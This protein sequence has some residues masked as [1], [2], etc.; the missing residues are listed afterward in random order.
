MTEI[1]SIFQTFYTGNNLND[2]FWHTLHIQR[3]ADN[4]E[5]WVDDEDRTAGVIPAEDFQLYIDRIK[6]G[7]FPGGGNYIGYLQ[8]FYYDERDLFSEMK[9]QSTDHSWIVP[10]PTNDIMT[11]KP[12]TVTTSDAFFLLPSMRI[13]LSM[14][15]LF[16]FRTRESNGLILYSGGVGRDKIAIEMSEGKMRLAY[17][18]GG[19]NMNTVVP[20]PYLLND[21]QWHTVQATLNNRGQF[22]VQV[23]DEV[24]DVTASDGDGQLNLLGYGFLLTSFLGTVFF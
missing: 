1:F 3:R 19:T 10:F 21:N 24:V 20:T 2:Y 23:D 14:K 4:I 13:G 17:N 16:K 18:L 11:Y 8:N 5:I 9:Q 7:S 15:I 22:S 6:F 12:V